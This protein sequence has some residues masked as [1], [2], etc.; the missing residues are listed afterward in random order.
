MAGH[1]AV[2]SAFNPG[3]KDSQIYEHQVKGARAIIDWVKQAGLKRLLFVRAF[4]ANGAA[5][6]VC[7][8]DSNGLKSRGREIIES[9][10]RHCE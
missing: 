7:D 4:A 2:I 5:V 6:F 9:P 1:D 3:W 8:I 10:P